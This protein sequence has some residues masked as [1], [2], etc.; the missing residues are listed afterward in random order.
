MNSTQ[1]VEAMFIYADESGDTGLK[2]EKASSQHFVLVAIIIRNKQDQ[3]QILQI[4]Q[5][6]KDDI[7][8]KKHYEIKF[9]NL[10]KNQRRKLLTRLKQAPFRILAIMADKTKSPAT[11]MS[12]Y[13]YLQKLLENNTASI[14]EARLKVDGQIS[15]EHARQINPQLKSVNGDKKNSVIKTIHFVDSKK[16]PCIQLADMIA[17]SLKHSINST[18]TNT[19]RKLIEH[20]IDYLDDSSI[21]YKQKNPL[22]YP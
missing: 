8:K 20:K 10:S 22:T 2:F 1:V 4:I 9:R 16:H 18:S 7:R 21:D 3:E 15:P 12:L 19:Y 5:Q 17:G 14:K 11:P 6:F 13:D